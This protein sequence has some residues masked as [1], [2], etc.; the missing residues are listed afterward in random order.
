MVLRTG[1]TPITLEF[2]NGDK[3][4]IY[5]DIHDRGIRERISAFGG[6]VEARM[7][8][9][10]AERYRASFND[11][12]DLKLN[13]FDDLMNL[14]PEQL[15]EVNK[16]LDAVAAIEQE[17]NSVV[18]DELDEVFK[19]KISD[20]VFRYCEPFDVVTVDGEKEIFVM[21]FLRWFAQEI[22]RLGDSNND[23]MKKYLGK[24]DKK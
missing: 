11:G 3:A 8:G 14:T 2:D 20:V 22:E 24:Y 23:A 13:N 6:K 15:D 1:K 18:K 17:Y 10:D 21:H 19:S 4:T 16:R 9:I 7:N 12:M 5:I